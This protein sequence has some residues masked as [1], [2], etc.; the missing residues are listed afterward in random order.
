MGRR[1][2]RVTKWLFNLHGWLGLL[3]GLFFLFY[4][5]S[6]SL[7]MFRTD[8][9]RYFNAELHNIEPKGKMLGIDGIYRNLVLNHQNLTKIVMHDFPANARDSYEFMAYKNVGSV[10][11]NY[12]YYICVDPYSGKILREGSYGE[13]QPSF[14]RWMYSLHYSLQLGMP[15]KLFTACIGLV[16]LLSLIS[17]LVIYRKHLWSA[18]CF[19]VK[20]NMKSGR[21][22]MSGL[23]R[24]VGVWATLFIAILFFSGF[25]M[26]RSHFDPSMWKLKKSVKNILVAVNIDTLVSRSKKLVNGF[27]PIA[28]N[29]PTTPHQPVLVK[30]HMPQ[31]GEFLYRGKA[32]SFAFDPD[33]GKLIKVSVIEKQP[34]AVRFDAW[35]YQLHIGAFGGVLIKWFYV[36]LGILPGFLSISGAVLWF[37]KQSFQKK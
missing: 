11:E 14:F 36:V 16:M 22:A 2:N 18:L 12:L 34:F 10:T 27:E 33:S 28:V 25:W 23:H 20:V 26:N 29:I 1:K 32:S 4:G 35:M 3:A 6:G 37:K 19:K 24:I 30:G 31:S 5:F 15:G 9:D 13:L 17:G 7:L 8:L 21:L